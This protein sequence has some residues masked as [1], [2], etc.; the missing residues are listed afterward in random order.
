MLIYVNTILL[1]LLCLSIY[2]L[3]GKFLYKNELYINGQGS[4]FINIEIY[5]NH[6]YTS[7]VC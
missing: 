3:L 4:N 5:S 6:V 1:K 2:N 7:F